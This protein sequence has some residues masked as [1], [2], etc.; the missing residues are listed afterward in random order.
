MNIE[1]FENG[2]FIDIVNCCYYFDIFCLK[3]GGLRN[4]NCKFKNCIFSRLE[5]FKFWNV[6]KFLEVLLI[7]VF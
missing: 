1:Y 5:V 2:M 6:L 3:Y 7:M 4:K